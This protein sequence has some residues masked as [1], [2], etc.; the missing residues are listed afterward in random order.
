HDWGWPSH[1]LEAGRRLHHDEIRRLHTE[2]GFSM[3]GGQ[4]V[5]DGQAAITR[6]RTRASTTALALPAID[7]LGVG[8]LTLTPGL[9]V[10]LMSFS[11]A[12][13]LTGE[14]G[15]STA[16]AILPGL[17]AYVALWDGLG[18]LAGV[19]RGFSPPAP[20]SGDVEPEVSVNY[21]AGLRY[22]SGRS[23]AELIGFYNDY[24]NLTDI[25]TQS[26]GCVAADLDRQFDAGAAHIYGLEAFAAHE[27]AL[28]VVRLPLSLAYTFSRGEFD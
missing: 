4:L 22:A 26:S 27:L 2:S 15:D 3:T 12:D 7:A 25:C 16:H 5:P 13:Q 18:A 19:Y 10:E 24:D 28:G 8:P 14:S 20:S 11:V 17:G 21:E 9:R 1:H 23:R 6:A